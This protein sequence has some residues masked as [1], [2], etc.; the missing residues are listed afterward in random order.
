MEYPICIYESEIEYGGYAYSIICNY[1]RVTI[2]TNEMDQLGNNTQFSNW[3]ISD[4][5]NVLIEESIMG[6]KKYNKYMEISEIKSALRLFHDSGRIRGWHE[7]IENYEP[8][9][10]IAKKYQKRNKK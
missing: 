10:L 3:H 1:F 7:D 2:Q 8:F 9:Y 4:D 6:I 5:G